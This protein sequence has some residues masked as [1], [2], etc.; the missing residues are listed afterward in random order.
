[1]LLSVVIP[2]Y[3]EERRLAATVR[4]L[5][6]TLHD[7]LHGEFEIVIVDDGSRDAT[8]EAAFEAADRCRRCRVITYGENAG[9]GHALRRGFA[10]ARGDLVAFFDA[11]GEIS[12]AT[13]LSLVRSVG[14]E[15]SAAVGRRHWEV[16]RPWH[17]RAASA[18]LALFARLAFDL[19]VPE[20]QAGV[21]VFVRRDVVRVVSECREDGY[22]FD[23]EL[24][25][26]MR[27][28]GLRMKS[29]DIVQTRTRSWRIGIGAGLR[30][31]L[32]VVRILRDLRTAD[33]SPA[34]AAP[35]PRALAARSTGEERMP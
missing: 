12:G 27:R 1:M 10:S 24:L 17:R 33:V 23:L 11:D 14:P 26:R 19:P 5:C 13:L 18:S 29:V 34:P 4:E 32:P 16:S 20:T 3:D 8:L 35:R 25:A 9:K 2:A 30:E 15:V 21:K 6:G 7:D 28:K 31:V 22:L